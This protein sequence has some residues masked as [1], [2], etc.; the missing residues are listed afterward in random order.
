MRRGGPHVTRFLESIAPA[1][2]LVEFFK[3]RNG[4]RPPESGLLNNGS[5]SG[6]R[7]CRSGAGLAKPDVAKPRETEQH[8]R[9]CGGLRHRG[10]EIAADIGCERAKRARARDDRGRWANVGEAQAHGTVKSADEARRDLHDT[11]GT[12]ELIRQRDHLFAAQHKKAR[13][14]PSLARST[15]LRRAVAADQ[16]PPVQPN[17]A[18]STDERLPDLRAIVVATTLQSRAMESLLASLARRQASA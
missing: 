4:K 16:G 6:D 3:A 2:E 14:P 13:K 15:I 12:R 8:H 1:R 11:W 17:K 7:D 5:R 10:A 18:S 9:P